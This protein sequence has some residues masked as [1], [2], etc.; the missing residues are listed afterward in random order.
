MICK[1][2]EIRDKMTFIPAI[3]IRL[4]VPEE[5]NPEDLGEAYLLRRCGFIRNDTAVLLVRMTA[6]G[7]AGAAS[8]DRFD[9]P[10]SSR[11]MT[12]AHKWIR[13]RWDEIKS[14]DV[15]DVQFILGETTIPKQS[16]RLG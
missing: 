9:W 15:V 7:E 11:T 5:L 6:S 4:S 16:E 10:G 13:E 8:Y 3:A 2:I 1:A 14:G 12:E